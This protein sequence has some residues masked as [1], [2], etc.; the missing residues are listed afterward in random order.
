M[1][2][3]WKWLTTLAPLAALLI[4]TTPASADIIMPGQKSISYCF[5]IANISE[6]PDYAF[7]VSF[8]EPI[9]G[10]QM[11]EQGKCV[12][13]YKLARPV[14]YAA[15]KAGFSPSEIP[16]DKAAEKSYFDTNPKLL[17]SSVQISN[18]GTVDE[19]DPRS[20]AVDV[21]RVVGMSGRTLDIKKE[22]VRYVYTNGARETLPYMSQDERPEPKAIPAP[23][24]LYGLIAVPVLAAIGLGALF[25]RRR[26]AH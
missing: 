5:E 12:Q 18:P 26:R 8:A 3:G 6:F 2:Q 14:I 7:I 11:I 9:G 4:S 15:P 16:A 1:L 17:K 20:E 13:F 24:Y 10:H 21:L 19:K 25:L 22:S 23:W